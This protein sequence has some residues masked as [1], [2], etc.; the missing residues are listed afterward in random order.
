MVEENQRTRTNW[1]FLSCE[2]ELVCRLDTAT[3]GGYT[4]ENEHSLARGIIDI[5]QKQTCATTS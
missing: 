3:D 1:R 5:Y 4:I 2:N